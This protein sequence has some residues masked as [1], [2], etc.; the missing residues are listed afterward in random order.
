MFQSIFLSLVLTLVSIHSFADSLGQIPRITF[1]KID[2]GHQKFWNAKVQ[3]QSFQSQIDRKKIV[4]FSLQ[5]QLPK[6]IV[7]VPGRGQ[8]SIVFSELVSKLPTQT[9]DV[10]LLDHR[11]QGFSERLV[12]EHDGGYVQ[13][14]DHYVD[15]LHQLIE[16][17]LSNY[18]EITLLGHSMGG[19]ISVRYL[20]KYSN[21]RVQQLILTNPMLELSLPIPEWVVQKLIENHG[22][23]NGFSSYI[24]DG[25]AYNP[26]SFKENVLT[27]NEK[28]YRYAVDLR[29]QFPQIKVG[30]ATVQWLLEALRITSEIT[31]DEEIKKLN[32]PITLFISEKDTVVEGDTAIS[33]CDD[34][35]SQGKAC[36]ACVFKGAKHEV[37]DEVDTVR[38]SI[39]TNIRGVLAN[40]ALTCTR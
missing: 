35:K 39:I 25:Q 32:I 19:A 28:L 29:K 33:I 22:E 3:T 24:P 21:N 10:F 5:S 6:A 30:D 14:F 13:N 40:E 26:P 12:D 16:E 34:L 31:Q 15:D 4:Y 36:Q 20:Q 38:K 7:V 37:L 9:H 17:Q 27:N 18:S 1:K 2:F 8:S 11:G 23:K